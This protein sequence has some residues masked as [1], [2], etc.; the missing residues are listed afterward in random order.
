MGS[1]TTIKKAQSFE[2]WFFVIVVLLAF[3]LF[4]IVLNYTWGQVSPELEAGLNSSIPAGETSINLTKTMEQTTGA[5]LAFDKLIPF[6]LIGLF[7]FV[8]IMAGGIMK[9]PVMIFVGIII[10]AVVILLAVVYSNLYNEITS[11]TEFAS[12]KADMPIQDKFMQYMPF[13]VFIMGIAITAGIL[14]SRKG[15]A[16]Y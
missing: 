1:I 10:L 5:G 9:H 11:T 8:L 13:I 7:A 4:F 16:G 6:V 14:W 3:S 15:G 12:T 2:S